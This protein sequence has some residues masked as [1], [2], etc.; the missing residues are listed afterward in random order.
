M[1][2]VSPAD[3]LRLAFYG[4]YSSDLQSETSIEDQHRRCQAW[5]QQNGH[6]IAATFE[7]RAIS[8]S[9]VAN[10]TGFQQLMEAVFSPD[11]GLNGI[12][13]DDLSRLSRDLGDTHSFI[14]RLKFRGLRVISVV[15]GID[16]SDRPSK[17]QVAVKGLLNEV[18]IDNLREQ[19]KRGLDGCFA[20]GMSTG[21]R[22]FGYR[23]VPVDPGDRESAMRREV[24]PEEAE[25]VRQIFRRFAAGEGEKSI[26]KELNARGIGGK[27]WSPNVL[28]NMLRNPAYVGRVTFN[29]Y[30]WVKNPDTGKRNYRERPEAHW[31]VTER[32]ELRILDQDL[33]DRAQQRIT[34]RSQASAGKKNN[35][36]STR[37]LSGLVTCDCGRRMTL[38]GHSY[39]CPAYFEQGLCANSTRFNRLS[40]ESLVIRALRERLLPRIKE[41]ELE[42]N[43]MLDAEGNE[44]RLAERNH[45]PR[46]VVTAGRSW[47]RLRSGRRRTWIPGSKSCDTPLRKSGRAGPASGG[48]PARA[49]AHGSWPWSRTSVREAPASG[50]WPRPSACTPVSCAA[51]LGGDA[52]RMGP[53]RPSGA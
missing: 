7:D 25:L 16:T 48:E 51:G 28:W 41:L 17:V 31:I 3:H 49:C 53:R 10:R 19:T 29:R 33:W 15:D 39:S 43:S 14:K 13:V 47:A 46:R 36:K 35:Q 12:I 22:L 40:L 44:S 32:P 5:A 1:R 45:S 4:R 52:S 50:V 30:E 42:I 27:P 37:L 6:E 18:Y 26:A 11:P 20:R 34:L 38:N 24:N 2:T 23:S 8:G 21:G 9:S